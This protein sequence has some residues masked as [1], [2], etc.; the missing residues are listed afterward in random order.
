MTS[1]SQDDSQ[2]AFVMMPFAA[3]FDDV[4]STV[5]DSIASV[6]DSLHVIRLDEVRAAGSITQDLV[7]MIR[8][9][10]LCVA[11]V[12]G[13]NPNVMWEVGFAAALGKP[14]IAITQQN[15]VLP[16]DI[17]DVRTLKYDRN[18]LAKTL[19]NQLAEALRATLE[20]YIGR[21][22]SLTA[23]QQRPHFRAIAVT[24]SMEV[25]RERVMERLKRLLSPYIG[26]GYNWYVGS[27]GNTDEATLQYLIEAEEASIA[28]VGH[29]AYDIS[30]EQLSLLEQNPS[31]SFID[32]A[33]EQ[34]PA[35][36]GAPSQRDVLFAS[37]ADLLVVMWNGVSQGTET[38]LGWLSANKKDHVLGFV[39]STHTQ[40]GYGSMAQTSAQP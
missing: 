21:R 17:K 14:V 19:R 34:I 13:A 16:F 30:E 4:Y 10:T 32:A 39:P 26:R 15:G 11:D 3:E 2:T 5:K 38:L 24:G 37:R 8:E 22:S 29:S 31:V 28:V 33:R 12:T 35:I 36:P 20:L 25:P 1:T 23:E 40:L 7:E 6:D 18:S 27:F 9:S